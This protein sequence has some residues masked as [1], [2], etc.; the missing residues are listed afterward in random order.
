M[1][2]ILNLTK[3]THS[4][5]GYH[6]PPGKSVCSDTY[7]HVALSLIYHNRTHFEL[8][9]EAMLKCGMEISVKDESE[10]MKLLKERLKND[11]EQG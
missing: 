9:R 3:E 2:S 11:T 1:T 8:V 10:D 6:T 7:P 4:H 5:G